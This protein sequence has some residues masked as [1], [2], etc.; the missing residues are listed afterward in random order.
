MLLRI[1]IVS[2]WRSVRLLAICASYTERDVMKCEIV[3]YLFKRPKTFRR[4][5]PSS[6]VYGNGLSKSRHRNDK[7]NLRHS[8]LT[9]ALHEPHCA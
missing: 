5:S 8:R 3:V 2:F 6:V 7:S 9:E 1:Y 4:K